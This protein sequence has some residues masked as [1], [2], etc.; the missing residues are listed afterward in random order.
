MQTLAFMTRVVIV[1]KTHRAFLRTKKDW[2]LWQELQ[3]AIDNAPTTVPCTSFPDLFFPGEEN[4]GAAVSDIRI[5]KNF[6]KRCPIILQCATYAI[7]T[8]EEYGVWGGLSPL[9]R[10]KLKRKHGSARQAAEAI[11]LRYRHP[12]SNGIQKDNR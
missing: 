5:A 11:E 6:C 4:I 12:R 7:E 8:D 9:D 1:P 3:D 10:K 2:L